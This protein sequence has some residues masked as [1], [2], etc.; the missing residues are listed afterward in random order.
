ML[1]K[2]AYFDAGLA[3]NRNDANTGERLK[4]RQDTGLQM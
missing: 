1:N 3:I 2:Q 4:N